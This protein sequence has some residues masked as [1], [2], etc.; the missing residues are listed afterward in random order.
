MR[1]SIRCLL[2][3]PALAPL[4]WGHGGGHQPPVPT[5]PPVPVPGPGGPPVPNPGP[6][7]PARP[8]NPGPNRPT[9]PATPA[10]PA[11]RTNAPTPANTG[12]VTPGSDAGP[13]LAGWQLWWDVNQHAYLDLKRALWD[14]GAL[15]GSD[16]FF[17][18]HGQRTLAHDL[19]PDPDELATRA[20]PALL[21]VIEGERQ[22]EV[23]SGCL[24]A[25]AKMGELPPPADGAAIEAVLTSFVDSPNQQ[26]A[27]T[28]ALALGV[29]GRRTSV[30]LL[31]DLLVGRG[32]GRGASTRS[33]D[34][35][36]AFAAYG[37]G[38]AA[39]G[40]EMPDVRRFAVLRLTRV[41][42]RGEF[43]ASDVGVACAYALGLV[44]L[45]PDPAHL[46]DPGAGL[47][48][49]ASREALVRWTLERLAD[50]R[51]RN[52]VRA[53]LARTA[54][55]LVDPDGGRATLDDPLRGE[56]VS[57]LVAA[58]ERSRRAD[59]ELRHGVLAALGRCVHA[60]DVEPDRAARAAL[61]VL[62]R[63][64]DPIAR[65][66]ATMAL[67]Q[68][69]GRPGS[70]D[71]A[72]LAGT[73]EIQTFLLERLGRGRSREKPLAALALGV[74]G[75]HLRRRG[76]P[77]ADE[78]GAALRDSLDQERSPLDLG[79]Y[80][81]ALG[82]RGDIQA[83]PLI[84][85][86]LTS[87]ADASARGHLALALGMTGDASFTGLLQR[88]LPG[89]IYRPESIGRMAMALAL[90]GDKR[91]VPEL[92]EALRTTRSSAV[93]AVH[94]WT[95]GFV[96][97]ARAIE[98]LTALLADREQPILLRGIAA[99]ALGFAAERRERPWNTALAQ[100]AH[101]PSAPPTLT[102]RTTGAGG[103]VLDIR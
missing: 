100:D 84:A 24:M 77:L 44:A 85:A 67:G 56:V 28:A 65:T 2:L 5:E 70:P 66:L 32:E 71:R 21:A 91:L 4:L 46:L 99:L 63:E 79:A 87:V 20:L 29:L 68:V 72:G 103:G 90:L 30:A 25:L 6:G 40:S 45:E 17:L 86:K 15:T 31:A 26:I 33:S 96:G 57:A 12:P 19:R 81:L 95:L 78:T 83:A 97:D 93:R 47:P 52:D 49:A 7:G 38:L 101:Y 14:P 62:A 42:D 16:D 73:A 27:E 34:R 76:L 98:P 82:L 36:R 60:G 43:A 10:P 8:A 55:A 53:H 89:E 75:H 92:V 39:A 13:D 51:L 37:L 74:Q 58:L 3:A 64:G 61:L 69:G 22:P 9:G 1:L 23:L 88:E 80:A 11:P 59:P 50:R 41:L 94:A 54:A 18:G 48:P 35:T 102:A